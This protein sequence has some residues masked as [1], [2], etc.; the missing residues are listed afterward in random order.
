M[1]RAV[2]STVGVASESAAAACLIL[3]IGV[4]P[5]SGQQVPSEDELPTATLVPVRTLE[6][7]DAP[8]Q[9]PAFV[10]AETSQGVVFVAGPSEVLT[11][12][13]NGSYGGS[14]GR[15]GA[16]P[17]EF[18]FISTL[19]LHGDTLWVGD[20]GLGRVTRFLPDGSL[21]TTISPWLPGVENFRPLFLAPDQSV[22]IGPP[23]GMS[24]AGDPAGRR[25]TVWTRWQSDDRIIDT[26]AVGSITHEMMMVRGETGAIRSVSQPF[27][28]R[29][30]I[31]Y[32]GTEPY[33]IAASG[34]RDGD[35]GTIV[36]ERLH[37]DGRRDTALTVRYRPTRVT[38]AMVDR[39]IH[40]TGRTLS[41]NP[42][43]PEPSARAPSEIAE[44]LRSAMYVPDYRPPVWDLVQ[45]VDGVIWIGREMGAAGRVSWII[46]NE[47]DGPLARLELPAHQR[48][49]AAAGTYVWLSDPTPLDVGRVVK[50]SVSFDQ[51]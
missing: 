37:F 47:T 15:Q 25:Q 34:I 50:Y 28:E 24:L 36:V 4:G 17:G 39:V 12:D 22:I 38:S 7:L 11:F 3:L 48:P 9:M 45:G 1:T 44:Q 33:A 21:V 23:E 35:E 51:D 20:A 41:W 40:E 27:G 18:A 26:L 29:T 10:L 42:G 32:T 49:M 8:M 2:S 30:P 14:I 46:A 43:A 31:S 16:G 13:D 5:A 6:T 19:G